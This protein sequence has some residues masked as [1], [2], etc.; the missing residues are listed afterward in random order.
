M[1]YD[2]DEMVYQIPESVIPR[3]QGTVSPDQSL[4]SIK[5]VDDPFS[6]SIFRKDNN[7]VIFDTSGSSL[8]FEDQYL[9]LRTSLPPQ[10][11]LYG[12]GE[13]T[14][15]MMLNTTNYTRTL[16]AR[17]SDKVPQG[18][19]LYGSHPVFFEMRA[20]SNS[21]HGVVLLNSNGMDVKINSTEEDGQYLEY[22]TL[23]GIVDLY[24]MAGPSPIEVAQQYSEI[25]GKPAMVPYWGFGFH[26]CRFGYQDVY[27]V[28][29]VVANYST[30]NIPLETMWTD[31]VSHPPLYGNCAALINTGLHGSLQSFHA[32]SRGVSSRKDARAS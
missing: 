20:S 30:A 4:L 6:F 26:Q 22:N 32:R 1:I 19:N 16:W 13:H 18:L 14:D 7:E 23:G 2:E 21:A 5:I 17:D 9:R 31:I 29:E 25:S 10:P 3:P 15:P 8:I 28:A 27:E 12:L 11:Q 24:F